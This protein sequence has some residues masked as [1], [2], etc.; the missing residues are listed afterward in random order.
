MRA[1]EGRGGRAGALPPRAAAALRAARTRCWP[2]IHPPLYQLCV[3]IAV[4]SEFIFLVLHICIM[5]PKYQL[6]AALNSESTAINISLI[7]YN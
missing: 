6:D 7:V 5:R 4:V 2:H 1:L 3:I